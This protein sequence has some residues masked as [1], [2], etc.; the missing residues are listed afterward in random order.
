M[1]LRLAW[2]N[3]WRNP[4]RTLVVVTAIAV[5]ISGCLVAM[6]VNFGMVA[7]MIDTAIASGLGHIQIHASGWDEKPELKVRLDDGGASLRT[8]LDEAP[9]VLAWAPRLRSEGLVASPRGSVGVTIIGV[10]PAR[11]PKISETADSITEGEWLG[12]RRRVVIGEALARRLKVGVGS[13][14]VLTVQDL[15]AEL[16]GQAFRVSGLMNTRSRDLDD[17]TVLMRIA[18]AQALLGMGAAISEVVITAIDRRDI[19]AIHARLEATLG[20]T[21]E[22]RTWEQLVPLLVYMVDT[23]DS[24]GL[25]LY[26]AIFIAMSFGIA[27]VLMMAVYERTREIGMMR[28]MGMGRGRV[29]AM[30]IVESCFVTALGLAV[31]IGLALLGVAA[32]GDGI[33]ISRFA[34][35]M[36]AYGMGT[37]LTPVVRAQDFASPILVGSVTAVLAGLWPAYRASRANP[38]DALRHY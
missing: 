28:A 17:G 9:D 18:E 20:A 6:A 24:M 3:V 19:A 7:E 35:S 29:V 31:G 10:D 27:N 13:K 37:L 11:E 4:R 22:V 23:F 30:V 12:E 25:V 16:T 1:V 5:G 2:R 26:A 38:A 21:S 32:L 33:D 36:D 15:T 8:I 34:D 14:V